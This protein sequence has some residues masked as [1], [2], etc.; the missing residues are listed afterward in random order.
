MQ[1]RVM[2]KQSFGNQA[3]SN[4]L[5]KFLILK[6]RQK[7]PSNTGLRF[8]LFTYTF[9]PNALK[10]QLN[11]ETLANFVKRRINVQLECS[12]SSLHNYKRYSQLCE[13][14]PLDCKKSN[15]RPVIGTVMRPVALLHI[16]THRHA[17]KSKCTRLVHC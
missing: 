15:C 2:L 17:R 7:M 12:L 14:K 5:E 10:G 1:I 8:P 6:C 13:V 3:Q 9:L 16:I 4:K 11:T